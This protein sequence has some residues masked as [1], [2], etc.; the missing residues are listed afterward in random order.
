MCIGRI[1]MFGIV[2]LGVLGFAVSADA[3]LWDPAEFMPADELRR[4]M[5]GYILTIVEESQV[6]RF[7]IEIL[8]VEK[9]AFAQGDLI[10]AKGAGEVLTH[11]GAVGGMSGSPAYVDGRLIRKKKIKKNQK[12]LLTKEILSIIT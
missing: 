5:K 2:L 8:S 7:P 10:W 6:E 11:T 3:V 12:I 1:H 9:S 4:G